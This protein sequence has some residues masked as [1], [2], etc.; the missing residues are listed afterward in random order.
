[1][2]ELNSLSLMDLKELAKLKGVQNYSK[3]K[4]AELIDAIL[5]ITNSKSK[6]QEVVQEES[7][8][9]NVEYKLTSEDDEYVE[10]IFKLNQ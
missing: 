3:L 2:E 7:N 1:M 6:E 9:K 5:E 4:K 8:S 10:S